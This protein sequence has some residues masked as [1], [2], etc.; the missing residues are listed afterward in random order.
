MSW[1]SEDVAHELG[2]IEG[3]G[4]KMV[5]AVN[6]YLADETKR[7]VLEK[8]L[9]HDVAAAAMLK[10]ESVAGPLSGMSF[11]VTGVLSRKREDVHQSIIAAG[12]E[13]HDKVKRGTRYLVAGAKV[14]QSKLEAATKN[15]TKII[16]EAEL[17]GLFGPA[18][19]S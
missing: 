1:S 17:E 15:G 16:S 11:C 4:P 14:G 18:T 5:D 8:L 19:P 12:G 13:V 3:F 9:A 2:A 10:P 6:A 7:R